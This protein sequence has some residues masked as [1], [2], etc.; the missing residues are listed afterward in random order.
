MIFSIIA[1]FISVVLDITMH[2]LST[3]YSILKNWLKYFN[4]AA[5]VCA[6]I[7][8]VFVVIT[9]IQAIRSKRR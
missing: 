4:I 9:I 6:A 7:F 5:I 2:S 1:V 3:R 8:V